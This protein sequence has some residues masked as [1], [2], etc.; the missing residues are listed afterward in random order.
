MPGVFRHRNYRLFFT[1]QLISLVGF[2]MQAIAQSW[3][4][5]RLTD[6]SMLLGLVS[7][8]G[9]APML[10]LTP[11]AGVFADRLPRQRI[12]FVTQTAMMSCASI[13]A[14]LALSG[15]IH[16]WH[17]VLI[18]ALSGTANAFDVPTR[19]SYTMAVVAPDE[20]AA[21]SGVTTIARSLGA[22]V[23]PALAGVFGATFAGSLSIRKR[24]FGLNR[25]FRR[26]ISMPDSKSPC[27]APARNRRIGASRSASVTG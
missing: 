12:L 3:L 8:A 21:A 7:F 11:F 1:G 24:N 27:L 16:V 13:F 26:P 25:I 18:A 5:Y 17:I 4:V 19:Q 9:Q 14:I 15:V 10:L 22:A 23:S 2:W 20:R 6:S